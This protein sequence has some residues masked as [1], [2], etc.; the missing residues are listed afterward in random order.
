MNKTVNLFDEFGRCIPNDSDLI[1]SQE[2]RRYFLIDKKEYNLKKIYERIKNTLDPDTCLSFDL[3]D[4]KINNLLNKINDNKKI[5]KI[6]KGPYF[7][8]FLPNKQY[9]DLG[10][11]LQNS[12]IPALKKSFES[13]NNNTNFEFTNHCKEN[14]SNQLTVCPKSRHQNLISFM[15]KNI[16]VGL[17]FPCLSEFSFSA[18]IEQLNYL[19]D[20]FSLAGGYDTFSTFIGSP[21]LLQR[22]KGYPPLLWLGS[23]QST[24]PNIGYH[25]EAYGYNL[26][27]NRRPHLNQKAEY[28][29]HSLVNFE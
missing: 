25:I 12:Y 4:K 8:F 18:S 17:Y 3:F 14:L 7:P 6:L 29:F 16:T 22:E 28:W 15:S 9:D 2:I 21:N 20:N 26:T 11:A 5:N 27:F 1:A 13:V 10:S 19:P 24:F 23:L